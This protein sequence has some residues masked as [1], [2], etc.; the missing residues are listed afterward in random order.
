VTPRDRT[1]TYND[2]T[3]TRVSPTKKTNTNIRRNLIPGV[4][5][6]PTIKKVVISSIK[7][8]TRNTFVH[9]HKIFN[10]KTRMLN[11]IV[12]SYKLMLCFSVTA[13]KVLAFKVCNPLIT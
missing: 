1:E 5:I 10:S 11:T 12:I 6:I 9:F 7:T 3:N 2:E 13:F 8:I 4:A